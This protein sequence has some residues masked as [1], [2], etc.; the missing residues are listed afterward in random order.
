MSAAAAIILSLFCFR[1]C[2]KPTL[3]TAKDPTQTSFPAIAWTGWPLSS[4]QYCFF[5]LVQPEKRKVLGARPCMIHPTQ[6][7]LQRESYSRRGG[8]CI[9]SNRKKSLDP[10][11]PPK[12]PRTSRGQQDHC[13]VLLL[14]T[15]L[16]TN[17]TTHE[18]HEFSGV[19]V[20]RNQSSMCVCAHNRKA[21]GWLWR[22][23]FR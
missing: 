4:P 9:W 7:D 20:D 3:W 12:R 17:T 23:S 14:W 21:G 2:P 18:R 15:S 11:V 1:H 22:F 13:T 19:C 10:L 8:E 5:F 6:L 16:N